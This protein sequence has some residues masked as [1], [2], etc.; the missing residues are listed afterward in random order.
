MPL[1]E[2]RARM[3]GMRSQIA[4]HSIYD[5]SEALITDMRDVSRHRGRFWPQRISPADSDA[6]KVVAG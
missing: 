5:W 1:A 3:E 2:R 4:S 6:R